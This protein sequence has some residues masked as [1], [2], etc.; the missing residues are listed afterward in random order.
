MKPSRTILSALLLGAMTLFLNGCNTDS[1]SPD[2]GLDDSAPPQAPTNVHAQS[3]AATH[4]D[5]LVWSPS[6]SPTVASYNVYSSESPSGI[7]DLVMTMPA[8]STV[9][10]LPVVTESTVEYYRVRAVKANG[11]PSQFT[12]ALMVERSVWT[13][14]TTGEPDDSEPSHE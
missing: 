7:G 12:P 8:G 4:R 10:L 3:D 2:P 1:T 11:A 14:T 9:Y 5:W 6:A 13:P